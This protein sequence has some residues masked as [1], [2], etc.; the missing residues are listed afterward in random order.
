MIVPTS[1]LFE[2]CQQQNLDV[3][4]N[5]LGTNLRGLYIRHPRLYRPL[6]E[7]HDSLITDERLLRCVLAEE[8]GH[9]F[10]GAGNY[11]IGY[12]DSTRI[13]LDKC[14]CL[15]MKWAVNYLV[16]KDKFI[17]KVGRYPLW[18]LADIFFVTHD[19]IMWQYNRLR[20]ALIEKWKRDP[21][22]E[23]E[24]CFESR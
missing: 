1:L 8:I 3:E 7:L 11:M 20:D 2:I 21:R 5:Y 17:L 22:E 19:F 4:Y 18:E 12:H 13:W 16:P 24:L 15:A 9:H 14:E 6:I 10:T 23:W